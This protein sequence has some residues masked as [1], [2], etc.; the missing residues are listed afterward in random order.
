[1]IQKTY[2]RKHQNPP[3]Q[4]KYVHTP[5]PQTLEIMELYMHVYAKI[6]YSKT[7]RM[8]A[9]ECNNV[10][11]RT[12]KGAMVYCLVVCNEKNLQKSIQVTLRVLLYRLFLFQR[13]EL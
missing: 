8:N 13:F 3:K 5:E 2:L 9:N 7:L 6:Y 11:T 10:I 4:G 12:P 1:M